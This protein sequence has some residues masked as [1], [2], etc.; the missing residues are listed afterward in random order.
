MRSCIAECVT[1]YVK[2]IGWFALA[3]LVACL[4][5]AAALAGGTAGLGGG[6]IAACFGITIAGNALIA[7]A[8]CISNC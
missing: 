2:N 3:V 5:A 7:L 1:A 8:A 6:A 4:V